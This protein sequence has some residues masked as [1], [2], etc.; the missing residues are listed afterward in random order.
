[1]NNSFYMPHVT[2]E[3]Y[4]VQMDEEPSFTVPFGLGF[5][6]LLFYKKKKKVLKR[7]IQ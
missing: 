1:M 2:G 5:V 6:Y 4:A 7:Q 3:T